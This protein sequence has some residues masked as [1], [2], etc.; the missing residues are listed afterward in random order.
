LIISCSKETAV[1]NPENKPDNFIR[2]V[3]ISFLPEIEIENITFY[4]SAGQPRDPL[5]IFKENG[6]NVI[7]LR[8]WKKP[9]TVHSSFEEVKSFSEKLR[10]YGFKIWLTVHYSDTWADPG[11]Q[12]LPQQWKDISFK[13]L[14]DSVYNYTQKIIKEIKPEFIQIGNEI[15]DGFLWPEGRITTNEDQFQELVQQGIKAVRNSS[16]SCKIM[17]HFAG[18]QGSDWFYNKVDNQDYD[19]IGISY[20]P[21][22]HGKNLENLQ[23]TLSDLKSKYKKDV[24]VAET[25]YPFTLG[26]NDWTHNIIG[27]QEQ[28]ILPDYPATLEGQEKFLFQIRSI[29]DSAGGIGISYWAPEWVAYKGHQSEE[30]SHWENLALFDF[31]NKVVPAIKVFNK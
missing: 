5:V 8:L 30:G 15:N 25:A 18:M 11:H 3:D 24:L 27:L 21:W 4:D 26:W 22:W 9:E 7:R 28:L 6:I 29:V 20:Y 12:E 2:S 14:K 23:F 17:L 19:I 1:S 31:E 10:K 16:K 13:D